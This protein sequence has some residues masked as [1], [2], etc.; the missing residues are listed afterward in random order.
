MR[1]KKGPARAGPFLR[2][3]AVAV[4]AITLTAPGCKSPVGRHDSVVSEKPSRRVAARPSVRTSAPTPSIGTGASHASPTS[5]GNHERATTSVPGLNSSERDAEPSAPAE[6][7]IG[8]TADAAGDMGLSGPTYAD[9]RAV[10]VVTTGD[11]LRVTAEVA[12]PLPARL[13]SGEVVGIGFDFF[14]SSTHEESDYQLFVDGESDGWYAY[15]QTPDGFPPFPGTFSIGDDTVI[16][17]VPWSA[18]GNLRR[19]EFSAFLDWSKKATPIN[20]SSADKAPDSG[21]VGFNR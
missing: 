6:T 3:H 4:L 14:E 9:L 18:V 7:T 1:R 16:L 12:G 2:F 19:G 11:R 13:A 17:E 5:A 21:R 8:R 15:L 20:Q 10:T